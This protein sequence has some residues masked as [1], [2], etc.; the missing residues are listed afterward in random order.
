MITNFFYDGQIRRYLLQAANV[1][2]GLQIQTGNGTCGTPEYM[3]VPIVYGSKDRV[4]A[5]IMAGNTQNKPFSI[6]TMAITMTSL[7]YSADRAHGIG[8]IDKQVF[9]PPGGVMPTD[10]KVLERIM[11]IPYMMT[12]GLDIYVSNTLQLHQILEQI[13][14]L[15]NPTLQIQTN[16]AQFDWTKI[17]NMQLVSI[18]N[19]ENYPAGAEKRIISWNLSFEMPIYI[20][21]P[22]D[23]KK[24]IVE[25]I[26]IRMGDL[27][28]F[29]INEIDED[30][31][32]V[33]F[34]SGSQWATTTINSDGSFSGNVGIV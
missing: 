14:M 1:F 31:N 12:I 18:T 5:G 27:N 6:P 8:T 23:F 20:A 22:A 32:S 24:N 29:V 21:P 30:G 28:N 10:L 34:N 26:T 16:D 19:E 15:F 25:S 11:P 7:Q 9:L 4:V 33:A 3:S 2:A 17:T 13:L